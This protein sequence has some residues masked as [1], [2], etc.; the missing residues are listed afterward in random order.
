MFKNIAVAGAIVGTLLLLSIAP[1]AAQTVRRHLH[2][3]IVPTLGLQGGLFGIN[4]TSGVQATNNWNATIPRGTKFN[5]RVNGRYYVF[6]SQQ[7]LAPGGKMLI[8]D[9]RG[10]SA[11]T[12]VWIPG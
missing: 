8:G 5:Y 3:A 9:A 1:G 11:C 7:A 10:A 6:T 4:V 2:C 12:D